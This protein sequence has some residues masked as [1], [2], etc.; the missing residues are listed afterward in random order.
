MGIERAVH[1]V[2]DHCESN[3]AHTN[4]VAEFW[5]TFTC[6]GFVVSAVFLIHL[7]QKARLEQR[8]KAIAAGYFISGC[9]GIV[10]H[11][12]LN[13]VMIKVDHIA[14]TAAITLNAW[15]IHGDDYLLIFWQIQMLMGAYMTAVFD[16]FFPVHMLLIGAGMVYTLNSK[17][18]WVPRATDVGMPVLHL[19]V[20]LSLSAFALISSDHV[21]CGSDYALPQMHALGQ[22][23]A[24]AALH[25]A[26]VLGA[27]L[28]LC[29]KKVPCDVEYY[30]GIV[31][32]V[33]RLGK[34]HSC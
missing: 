30:L 21:A 23:L 7:H 22:V 26:T 12:T 24:A 17:M 9:T 31:P 25:T 2:F 4:W 16:W 29:E 15:L 14:F 27:Y 1:R 33:V 10:A 20:V 19:T 13:L 11:A 8:Y 3:H 32:Y 18:D 34:D 28:R 5:N 6:L